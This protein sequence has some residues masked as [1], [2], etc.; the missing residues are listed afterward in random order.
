MCT[1]IGPTNEDGLFFNTSSNI[2]PTPAPQ[3]QLVNTLFHGVSQIHTKI[4]ANVSFQATSMNLSQNILNGW[5]MGGS[6]SVTFPA[7]CRRRNQTTDQSWFWTLNMGTYPLGQIS[8][9]WWRLWINL[10][11]QAAPPGMTPIRP[12]LL[13]SMQNKSNCGICVIAD[14]ATAYNYLVPILN[15]FYSQISFIP[16]SL[17]STAN[18]VQN[19]NVILLYNEF[20]ADPTNSSALGIKKTKR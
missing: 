11:D 17:I 16:M 19:C 6:P 5:Y 3:Q 9:E 8:G 18:D 13:T 12:N 20:G 10:I 2:A 1:T 15:V 14:D 7:I 4:F